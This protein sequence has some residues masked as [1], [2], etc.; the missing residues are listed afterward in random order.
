[1]LGKLPFLE[2]SANSDAPIPDDLDLFLAQEAEAI[3]ALEQDAVSYVARIA[4]KI[5]GH[6]HKV[7]T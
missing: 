5:G 6:L 1:M 7:Q 2:S 4:I 3:R